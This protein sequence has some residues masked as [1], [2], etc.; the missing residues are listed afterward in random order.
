MKIESPSSE[1][2]QKKPSVR[3]QYTSG[4]VVLQQSLFTAAKDICDGAATVI[5]ARGVPIPSAAMV[6][7]RRVSSREGA[8]AGAV[9][10]VKAGVDFFILLR[11]FIK[12][13]PIPSSSCRPSGTCLDSGDD[14]GTCCNRARTRAEE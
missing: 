7:C 13:P 14:C 3:L 9:Q 12:E 2:F 8:G 6:I 5:D 4:A 11:G 10:A 1:G